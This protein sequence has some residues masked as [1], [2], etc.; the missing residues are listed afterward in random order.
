MRCFLICSFFIIIW[1]ESCSQSLI[2]NSSTNKNYLNGDKLISDSNFVF[3]INST[4]IL[5]SDSCI[6][7]NLKVDYLSLFKSLKKQKSIDLKKYCDLEIKLFKHS[8]NL[9]EFQFYVLLNTYINGKKV[10][11][12]VCYSYSNFPENSV[13]NELLYYLDED[14]CLWLIALTYE[15]SSVTMESWRKI[16]IDKK[17]GILNEEKL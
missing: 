7:D 16:K 1:L 17:T 5:N 11:S 8:N 9:E 12:V 15:E 2:S 13:A 10:D 3:K 6:I 14:Y 4:C